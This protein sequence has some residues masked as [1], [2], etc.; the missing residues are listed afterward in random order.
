MSI[1]DRGIVAVQRESDG[2]L[3]LV[4]CAGVKANQ[5][6]GVFAK[7]SH[8]PSDLIRT[9]LPLRKAGALSHTEEIAQ[10]S[11]VDT[12]HIEI[13]RIPEVTGL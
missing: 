10:V 11:R 7:Y 6:Y 3:T 1:T 8:V 13:S 9:A 12:G 2:T 5:P 4:V